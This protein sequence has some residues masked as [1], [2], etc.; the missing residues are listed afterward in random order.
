MDPHKLDTKAVETIKQSNFKYYK[1]P[2]YLIYSANMGKNSRHQR[3]F[4]IKMML[5]FEDV[6]LFLINAIEHV[7]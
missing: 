3:F 5:T 4:V 2:G 7:N 6:N 1:V